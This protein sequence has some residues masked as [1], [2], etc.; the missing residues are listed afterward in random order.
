ERVS[1]AGELVGV[2][3][4][5]RRRLVEI[6]PYGSGGWQQGV[7]RVGLPSTQAGVNG[8][9]GLEVARIG[10]TPSLTAE[11]T[12]NPDF[13]Q[14]E[15]DSQVVNL[16][17]FSVFFPEKRDFFLENSGIFLFGRAEANQLFFTRRIGLTEGGAP[18]PIDYGAKITGKVGRY[19][20]G[21]LQVQTRKLGES[22]TPF[23]VPRAQ[24]TV[25]RV[26]RDIFER[27]S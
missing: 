16:S 1:Q 12:A 2:G 7:P 8:K 22:R 10:I 6:K 3:E 5:R 18:V 24:F 21:F 17:R 27:S 23:H 9:V 11:F 25:A 13:G 20:I 4:I 14:A 15:V 19:N 26:K